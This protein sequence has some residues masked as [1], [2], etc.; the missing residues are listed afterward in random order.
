MTGMTGSRLGQ[1]AEPSSTAAG[2]QI[3]D[4]VIG[5]AFRYLVGVALAVRA[6]GAYACGRS[7]A[8]RRGSRLGRC[9]RR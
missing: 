6:L 4:D 5:G 7:V 2:D 9:M 3:E 8:D 1:R